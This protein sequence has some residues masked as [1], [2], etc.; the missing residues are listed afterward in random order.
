MKTWKKH[1]KAIMPAFNQKVLDTFVEIFTSKSIIL[2]DELDK[3]VGNREL[4]LLDYIS[5][6]NVDIICRKYS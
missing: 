1:R 4:N 6:C 5:R 2:I 3:E